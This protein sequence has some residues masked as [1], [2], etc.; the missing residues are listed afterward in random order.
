MPK[1][2]RAPKS[3]T[4][5][6]LDELREAVGRAEVAYESAV[7]HL[8]TL[9]AGREEILLQGTDEEA[10]AHDAEIAAARR[11][12]DRLRLRLAPLQEQLKGAE[13]REQ[14]ARAERRIDSLLEE[15]E[16]LQ[17]RGIEIIRW[18]GQV[19]PEM[20]SRLAE[21]RAADERVVAVAKELSALKFEGDI[22]QRPS[23]VA[24]PE[25]TPLYADTPPTHG[26]FGGIDSQGGVRLPSATG[27]GAMIFGSGPVIGELPSEVAA[28]ANHQRRVEEWERRNPRPSLGPGIYDGQ[29]NPADIDTK[30][31]HEKHVRELADWQ[32][33]RDEWMQA[34]GLA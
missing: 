10:A 7:E 4:P 3:A 31:R 12:V 34:H 6:D 29:G 2:A 19:A 17:E 33:R 5:S 13:A 8:E 26:S 32:Q 23:G 25:V 16:R 14:V 20:A 21:L 22:P 11:Q 27:K 28:R 24:R 18:Y 1:T 30:R 15:A 9:E